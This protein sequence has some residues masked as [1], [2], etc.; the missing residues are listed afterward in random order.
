MARILSYRSLG[1]RLWKSHLFRS[2]SVLSTNFSF[3]RQ[4]ECPTSDNLRLVRLI[5]PEIAG[6][7][8]VN[9]LVGWDAALQQANKLGL[10][11]QVGK[12]F[13]R[14]PYVSVEMAELDAS[15]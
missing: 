9:T 4:S 13:V 15:F 12:G 3:R 11:L 10:S 6:I 1:R 14:F 8:P 7:S 5:I 2:E